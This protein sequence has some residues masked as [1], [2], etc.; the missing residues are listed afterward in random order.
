MSGDNLSVKCNYSQTAT[1]CQKQHQSL[2]NF[3]LGTLCA[4]HPLTIIPSWTLNQP[5][6]V[7]YFRLWADLCPSLILIMSILEEWNNSCLHH[8][9][10]RLQWWTRMVTLC[11]EMWI[12]SLENLSIHVSKTNFFSITGFNHCVCWK[13]EWNLNPTSRLTCLSP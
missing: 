12:G 11:Y 9:L 13:G 6:F 10:T 5:K 3:V 1:N 7:T 2:W 8:I 4:G